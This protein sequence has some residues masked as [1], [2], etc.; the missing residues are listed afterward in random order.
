[1]PGIMRQTHGSVGAIIVLQLWLFLSGFV[2]LLRAKLNAEL[3]RSADVEPS[4]ER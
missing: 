2:L 4:A 3:M 1:M